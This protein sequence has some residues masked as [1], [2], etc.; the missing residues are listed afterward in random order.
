M[1]VCALVRVSE[2]EALPY[3]MLGM[4]VVCGFRRALPIVFQVTMCVYFFGVFELS[5][6]MRGGE[7]FLLYAHDWLM[8][9]TRS[10]CSL[11][12]FQL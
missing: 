8:Y 9:Q 12:L 3:C 10:N 1:F 6:Y 11:T 4:C 7:A 5:L 2:C